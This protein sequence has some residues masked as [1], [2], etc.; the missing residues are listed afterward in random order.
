MKRLL[1]ILT[2]LTLLGG[3]LTG[4]SSTSTSS[5]ETCDGATYSSQS[6]TV[7]AAA[8]ADAMEYEETTGYAYDVE[9]DTEEYDTLIENG[10]TAVSNSPVSTFSADV[11]TASY[12]NVRRMINSGYSIEDIPT[13]AVRTEEMLNYFSYDYAAPDT[14]E[15]FGMTAAVS[16]CPWNDE[17]L[18]LVFGI[19]TED[20]DYEG[21]R[22]LQLCI[23]N[24]HLRLHGQQR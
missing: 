12:C 21:Y 15:P 13:G 10:F 16:T 23:F 11:D 17:S 14:G 22:R 6:N 1:G 4:C 24:R 19:T 3:I 7:S 18:L 5:L 9:F 20:C 2:A 8:G